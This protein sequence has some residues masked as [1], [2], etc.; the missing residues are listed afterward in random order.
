MTLSFFET[1]MGKVFNSLL[2]GDAIWH[3]RSL[4]TLILVIYRTLPASM[5]TNHE[6]VCVARV[7]NL[8]IHNQPILVKIKFE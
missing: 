8:H 3:L 4:S 6:W 1:E 5:L 2:H 7:E